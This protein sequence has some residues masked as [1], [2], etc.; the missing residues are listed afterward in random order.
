MANNC[1]GH[2]HKT[3]LQTLKVLPPHFLFVA[4]IC[5]CIIIEN[6]DRVIDALRKVD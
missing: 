2:W 4:Q 5:V 1:I 3:G 6:L